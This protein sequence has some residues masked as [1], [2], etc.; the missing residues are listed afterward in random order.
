[1][2]EREH[3]EKKKITYV[4]VKDKEVLE[5]MLDTK[6]SYGILVLDGREATLAIAKGTY[7][8]IVHRLN[9]MAHA[10]HK[11][12]GQSARRYERIIE[13][14][15]E[16]YY[17]RVGDSM[18]KYFLNNVKAVLVGGPGPTKDFFLKS[19][20]FNYQ[21]KVLGPVDTGYTDE[22]GIHEILSKS[23]DLLAEQEAIKEKKEINQFIKEVVTGGLATYG[24][25][26]VRDAI[27][28]KQASKLLVSEGLEYNVGKYKNEDTGEEEYK[29]SKEAPAGQLEKNGK[30]YNL[31]EVISLIDDLILLARENNI[32]VMIVSTN[33]SEGS[34]FLAGFSG[35]GALLRYKS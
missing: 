26:Q 35:L 15:I 17:Q 34:Q 14:T 10:K 11:A 2:Q 29:I 4:L 16:K 21:I 1:M 28:R 9:S 30:I 31:I 27:I 13:E 3:G 24:E 5:Q 23:D 32:E 20:T 33:T 7:V 18:D 19:K 25:K 22:T 12:G 8:E 6:D